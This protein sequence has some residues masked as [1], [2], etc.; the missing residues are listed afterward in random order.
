MVLKI[1]FIGLGNMGF[2]M[3]KRLVTANYDVY[4]FN[5]SKEREEAFVEF[6]GSKGGSIA[7]IGREVDVIMTCLPLP[8]DVEDVYLSDNGIIS[9][10]KQGLTLIDFSTVSPDLNEKINNHAI[11]KGVN[12]LDAPVSGGTIGAENGTLSIMVGGQKEIFEIVSP[13]LNVLGENI[14]HI[15]KVGSGSIVKLINQYMVSVHT[16]SVSEALNLAEEAGV[17]KDTVFSILN[18]SFAQSRIFER[19]YKEFIAKDQYTAGFELRLL[20][21]DMALVQEMASKSNMSLPVGELVNELLNQA[22]ESKLSNK[23][24]SA[25]YKFMKEHIRKN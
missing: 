12:F 11:K 3:A 21:K 19:H 23:D 18:K 15:G 2:P 9:N 14:F 13:L 22:K 6:G 25:M 1:G 4:G 24:M 16:Q 8:K 7:R 10:A 5:R 17:D 20:S